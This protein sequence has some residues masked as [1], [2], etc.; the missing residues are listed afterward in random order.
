[1]HAADGL[2]YPREL[3]PD[4][5]T[6]DAGSGEDIRSAVL[7]D[8]VVK[9]DWHDGDS[10][11]VPLLWL[12]DHCECPTCRHPVTL[13][14][15]VDTYALPEVLTAELRV[16]GDALV[17]TWAP[18]A[19]Q[20]RF[21]ARW[22]AALRRRPLRPERVLWDRSVADSL[23]RVTHAAVMTDDAGVLAWLEKLERF[24]LCYVEGVP[25]TP[26]ATRALAER[27]AYIRNTIFGGF[28][29]FTADLAFNDTAYTTLAIGPHTD[30]TYSFDA[31]G[32]QMF[33]C[34]QCVG[35]GGDS[36]FVDGF[37]IAEIMRRDH[38]AD[39][40]LLARVPIT[41]QYLDP[42]HGTHLCASRP[43][44]RL[45]DEGALIQVSFN[46]SDRAPML[47]SVAE[48]HAFYRA[49]RVFNR[50]AN[51]PAL[52]LRRRLVPGEVVLFDNWR[53]LHGRAAFT[54]GRRLCGVYL[55]QED[56]QSRLRVLRARVGR[57]RS[58]SSHGGGA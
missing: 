50:L 38:A 49:L 8:D 54:G 44:F 5:R 21:H 48:T 34:L 11:A 56:V 53:L 41:G 20:S 35:E 2:L 37:H 45:D 23:P 19:H 51:D 30:G 13:Q 17:L 55:N 14:R 25:S 52:E 36:T 10:V 3:S 22:L 43:V 18:D 6:F 31:P 32:A 47:R 24:G 12:R 4:L 42:G 9:I 16:E 57:R 28:W 39:F 15:Q 46:N 27:V 7:A 40:D 29:E 1:M 58:G 33:H 26:E